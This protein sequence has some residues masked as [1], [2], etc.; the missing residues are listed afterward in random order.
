MPSLPEH[1]VQFAFDGEIERLLRRWL[2]DDCTAAQLNWKFRTYYE[3]RR[4]IPQTIKERLQQKRNRKLIVDPEW[5]L[6]NRFISEFRIAL[7]KDLEADN[8]SVLHPWPRPYQHTLVLTH[9]VET[10]DG[11]ARIDRLAR[12][13]EHSGVRSTW[14]VIP[15]K[16]P[17]DWG[18]LTDLRD[19]GHE[20]GVHGYNHDGRLFA[21]RR[22]FDSRTPLINKSIQEF[23]A[24]GF[25]SPM[26][27]RQ[28]DW[29]QAIDMQYDASC[30][31][32]D[33]F[34]AMPGGVGGIWPFHVGRFVEIPYTM[35]QDHTLIRLGALDKNIWLKKMAQNRLLRGASTLITHPDYLESDEQLA[36]YRAFLDEATTDPSLW[37]ALASDVANWWNDR[38]PPK[39]AMLETSQQ[40]S[41]C[42]Q[43]QSADPRV[44]TTALKNLFADF[45]VEHAN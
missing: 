33:P 29:M 42:S 39:H 17:I 19:R 34:Q 20:I 1:P 6:G 30:F 37:I 24:T 41:A 3:L 43:T 27:H 4:W 9:D 31:D 32:V 26:V 14:F 35:P 18:L 22:R 15:H 23:S 28:L 38:C 8:T 5:Y 45:L 13:E 16:Y 12:L 40:D 21:S 44:R 2:T 11:F 10:A 36:E 7:R 25:R